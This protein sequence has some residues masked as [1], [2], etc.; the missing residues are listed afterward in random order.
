MLLIAHILEQ[1]QE[2]WRCLPG[3]RRGPKT[4]CPWGARVTCASDSIW[5]GPGRPKTPW[6]SRL[7]APYVCRGSASQPSGD[8]SQLLSVWGPARGTHWDFLSEKLQ[9][10]VFSFFC[11]KEDSLKCSEM[12]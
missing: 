4:K 7:Q 8:G 5:E 1:D 9:K 12:L 11:K 10:C 3:L 6:D 2:I